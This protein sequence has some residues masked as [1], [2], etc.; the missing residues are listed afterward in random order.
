[1]LYISIVFGMRFVIALFV[2]VGDA[3]VYGFVLGIGFGRVLV[4]A[5]VDDRVHVVVLGHCCCSCYRYNSWSCSICVV[6][7][8]GLLLF[9]L[10]LFVI[11]LLLVL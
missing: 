8:L 10:L 9:W 3:F 2:V 7:G 5:I 1:M 6:I 11:R 4:L